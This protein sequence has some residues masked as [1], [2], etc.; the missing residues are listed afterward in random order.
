MKLN[1]SFAIKRLSNLRLYE[2]NILM[3]KKDTYFD[4]IIKTRFYEKSNLYRTS[5]VRIFFCESS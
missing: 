1:F 5:N 4:I 3:V 2:L